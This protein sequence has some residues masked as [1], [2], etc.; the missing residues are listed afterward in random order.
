MTSLA[1]FSISAKG[2]RIVAARLARDLG[3][4]DSDEK[5]TIESSNG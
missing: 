2:H 3:I 4:S 1:S 5:L